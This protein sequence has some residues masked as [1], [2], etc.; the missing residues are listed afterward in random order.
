MNL[1]IV[2]P[3]YNEEKSIG[4]IID[5]T[6]QSRQYIIEN[7][8]I[9]NVEVI[10]V[11]DGSRD[12]TKE[13]VEKYNDV[14]LISYRKNKGYGAAIKEGFKEAKGEL[15]GFLD[16][17]GTCDPRFFV[18][19]I[20]FLTKNKADI[21][22]GSR[23]GSGSRMPLVRRLGNTLFANVINFLG[24]VKISDCASGMRVLKRE[25]LAILYPLPDGMHFTPAMSCKALMSKE[26]KIIEVPMKYEER[27]GK[28]KLEVIKDGRRFL[29]TI[30][31][32]V[33][34]YKPLKFLMTMGIFLIIVASIYS[35]NPIVYYLTTRHIEEWHIYRLIAIMVFVVGG[36]N[37]MVLSLLSDD[38][39]S[40]LNNRPSLRDRSKSKLLKSILYPRYFARIGFL[41]AFCGLVLNIK[42]IKEYILTGKIHTHWVYIL[43]GALL[44]LLGIEIFSYGVLEKMLAMYRL[45]KKNP[46]V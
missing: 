12:K 9:K 40:L 16:A 24:N 14:T 3:V 5:R 36:I 39:S 11:D 43:T 22:I 38:L 19:L 42:T 28:S 10:V 44:I 45:R 46:D 30:L 25:S 17:D 6:L 27:E 31:E 35:I 18:S 2:I 23:L 29:D 34:F 21:A 37:F 7:T 15:L 41:I 4:P 20:N 26:L 32:M 33:L 8:A 13:I 1:S